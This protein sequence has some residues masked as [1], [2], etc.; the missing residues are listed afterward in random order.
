MAKKTLASEAII[1]CC[2]FSRFLNKSFNIFVWA[3][4]APVRPG[5]VCWAK[6]QTDPDTTN[7]R[8]RIFLFIVLRLFGPRSSPTVRT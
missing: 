5:S 7:K 3:A 1:A 2:V 6:Q 4:T 8:Q